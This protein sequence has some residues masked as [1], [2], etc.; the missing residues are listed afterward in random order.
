MPQKDIQAVVIPRSQKLADE[1]HFELVDAEL[2]KEG[3]GRYL[4]IYIDR[5]GGI[6]LDEIET[7]HRAIQPQL[8]D[9]DYDF[10]EVGSPGLDRPLKKDRDFGRAM[11]NPVEV[12]LYKPLEGK[13]VYTGTLCAW[14]GETVE[15]EDAQGRRAL[16][17]KGIAVMKPV[18]EIDLEDEGDME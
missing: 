8:E 1:M 7:Y 5:P 15:I 16:A 18:V 2:V 10:L 13:K 14:N 12:R 11:G 17:R 3:P 6:T 9:V 4:R